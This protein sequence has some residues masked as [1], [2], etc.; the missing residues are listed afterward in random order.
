MLQRFKNASI[1]IKLWSVVGG[2][3]ALVLVLLVLESQRSWQELQTADRRLQGALFASDLMPLL[4]AVQQHRGTVNAVLGGDSARQSDLPA[5]Q[6]RVDQALN[7]L[8]L[9]DAALL[10]DWKVGEPLAQISNDWRTLRSGGFEGQRQADAYQAHS[11]V[12]ASIIQ[13]MRQSGRGSTLILD[14]SLD[15]YFLVDY[16]LSYAAPL[17][18]N[19]GQVR[20]LGENIL[21]AAGFLTDQQ[22]SRLLELQSRLGQTL[23]GAQQ[24]LAQAGA[25][26]PI[27]EQT[28]GGSR[29]DLTG[30]GRQATAAIE[31]VLSGQYSG[32][33]AS[34]FEVMTSVIGTATQVFE[35]AKALLIDGLEGQKTDIQ[36]RMI[37]LIGVIS[38]VFLM[39]FAAAFVVLRGISQRLAKVE[40][41]FQGI[42]AGDLN[43]PVEV[44]SQDN[45]GRLMLAL[46]RMQEKL[47]LQI[48][49]DRAQLAE[50]TRIKQ[51]LDFVGRPVL[52]LNTAGQ[53]I[54][55]NESVQALFELKASDIRQAHPAFEPN[56]WLQ[57]DYSD[58][59]SAA[60]DQRLNETLSLGFST[61]AVQITPIMDQAGS[62]LGTVVEWEDRSE[63]HA[64]E[65]EV[66][67]LVDRVKQGDLTI[68][69]ETQGKSEFFEGLAL[70]LN[71]VTQMLSEVIE[72]THRV[73]DAMARGDLRQRI[74]Q[75]YRGQFGQLAGVVN[76]S[77]DQLADVVA[78]I[79]AS[80]EQIRA[81]AEEIAQGNADLSHRTEE[82][83]SSLEETASSME[84]MTGL[85]R[86]SAENAGNASNLA[87]RVTQKAAD[88]G[89][90]V[91]QSVSAMQAITESSAQISDIITVIDEIAFQ[92]NLLA[93][94][95]A[96]EAARAGEQGRGFAV[97]AGEVRSLAQRSAEAAKEIKDLIR[98]STE[99]VHEGS[100]LVTASGETLTELIQSMTEVSAQVGQISSS[101]LEQ[102]SGIEQV[103]TAVSQMDEMTQQN[104]ALVEQ[105]SAA[106]EAMAEQ[107]RQMVQAVGFFQV[108]PATVTPKPLP[109]APDLLVQSD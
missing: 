26:N 44:D 73:M 71:E 22:R 92:T 1:G 7:R 84:Q 27:F 81:G 72:D 39:A 8:S 74:D 45:L 54:Y 85:V 3:S 16:A 102:S 43:Q 24:A 88:G 56:Q 35:Q 32:S 52:I 100:E 86:Q 98:N 101:A 67:H 4:I 53:V 55:A 50:N 65:L 42:E 66:A 78:Q 62:H 97:V 105:A 68:R 95:A 5:I 77:T 29:E 94:N 18:E 83:A 6:N 2:L 89:T 33:P 14:R 99:K 40:G 70:G 17:A 10:R 15:T 38:I 21:T 91:T 87:Q 11:E 108:K 61:I 46:G 49:S 59:H 19:S 48:E 9:R 103:N 107:S 109:Y 60:F 47:R 82:Q 96:V 80:A 93:L 36:A 37:A 63:I 31:A 41:V 90:V 79:N 106:S 23:S 64:A 51:G 58:V 30:A 104:A 57:M 28:L 34:F 13:L 75:E 69:L 12:T 20:S 25:G 76:Q